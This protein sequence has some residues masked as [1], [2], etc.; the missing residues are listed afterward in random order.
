MSNLVGLRN[1]MERVLEASKSCNF[2]IKI[3]FSRI[4]PDEEK[5]AR[6]LDDALSNYKS[7]VEYNLM[8]YRLT[9]DA[10]GVALWDMDVVGGD[11]VNPKN[12]FTWS[13]AF[14]RMLGFES[15]RDFPN[16][17]S[18]WSERLHPE[19][20]DATLRA[21]AAHLNDRT[22]RTP[23]DL[24]S[25]LLTKKGEYRFFH[26]FGATLRDKAGIP[27]RVAGALEDVTEKKHM[28]EQ[29]AVST[30]RF[31]L[32][33]KSR[34]IALWDMTVDP[35]NPVSGNNHFW[36][37][38]ELRHMLGF[39]GEHDF[40]N[41]LSSWSERL[42]PEDKER[43]LN[44]F[45]AHLN[46][47]KG[48]TPYNVEYRIQKKDGKYLWLRADGSTQ[49]TTRGVPIRVVGSV[50]D[51]SQSLRKDDLDKF[52]REF[53]TQIAQMSQHVAKTIADSE[54][55]EKAQ[56]RNRSASQESDKNIA[57][58]KTIVGDIQGIASDTNILS[59]NAAIEAARA[60][61]HGLGFA[62]VADEVR[63]LANKS[64]GHA[65]KIEAKL[66][67]IQTASAVITQDIE[68]TCSLVSE[69]AQAM[70]SV[71]SALDSLTKTY[72][73]LTNLVRISLG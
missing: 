70:A 42:H 64:A 44:A 50:E 5:V 16:V 53:D 72:K 14:R 17:L 26:A 40:P 31:Q 39:S 49:R 30:L 67:N 22:G 71:Q 43:T 29:V 13:A 18:S 69:Q 65:A 61:Q 66:K 28:Q 38:D 19:D 9:S 20:K 68:S 56:E 60:G 4:S 35:V 24:T 10:L 59:L 3:D 2:N 37:S 23:Y 62:V 1:E 25:R 33:M 47:H 41:V 57:E 12:T 51:I 55:L 54:L 32:M 48:R 21:F 7:A 73:E 15:E 11:P 46:D 52:I 45:A 6:L 27:L 8:K 36:W 34:E 63:N 58:T